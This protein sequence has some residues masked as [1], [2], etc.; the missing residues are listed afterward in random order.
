MATTETVVELRGVSHRFATFDALRDVDL[1]VKRGDVYGLLGLNGAGKTT[2]LRILLR[3]L[4]L[5]TGE[6][7]LFGRPQP[8]SWLEVASRIGATIEAP[9]FYPHLDGRTNLSLLWDLAGAPEGRSPDEALEVVGLAD[10]ADVPARKY[11]QGMLQ[12]L[13][14]AQSLLGR[15][16]L[17]LMDEPTAN[18]D[19]LGIV[20]VRRIIRDL[21]QDA[22]VTVI[23]SSHQLNEV[24]EVCNRVAI[25]HRGR[26]LAEA[27]VTELFD[28]QESRIEIEVDRPEPAHRTLQSL[29][30]C[31]EPTL[32]EGLLR[33]R[34]P[35]ARRSELNALLI[36]Q[37]FEVAGFAERRP[38]LEEYFRETIS[39]GS[40]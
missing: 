29:E 3:L 7:A 11:S 36:K 8:A 24:E 23:L 40:E 5:Q 18:L 31:V 26:K 39:D 14:I 1:E 25:L 16:Q 33:A 38:S 4:R 37:G 2:T 17:L 9:A 35:R 21:S 32:R 20:E 30:W 10:A 19:P 6:V 27:P 12:R 22:D 15:P 28:A 13:Y 34:V